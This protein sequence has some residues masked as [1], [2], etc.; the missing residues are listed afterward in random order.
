[1]VG[2]PYVIALPREPLTLIAELGFFNASLTQDEPPIGPET[3]AH[4]PGDLATYPT[5]QQKDAILAARPNGGLQTPAQAV[6]QGTSTT[7][8]GL[9]VGEEY[10]EGSSLE[11]GFE[12]ELEA[13]VATVMAGFSVGASVENSL[14]ITSGT[15]TS[16]T[17]VVGS[18][19]SAN[20]AENVY[21]FGLFTYAFHQPGMDREFQVLNY[22]VE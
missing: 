7:E 3:F 17:G 5:A 10:T 12:F 21:S 6:G 4:T 19:D 16:Y 2:T 1:M 14:Q 13:T 8:I 18:I 11:V 15:E 22:W 9:A 20:F